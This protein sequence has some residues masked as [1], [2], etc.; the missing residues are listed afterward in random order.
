MRDAK[1]FIHL[2]IGCKVAGTYSDASG[3][4]GI[5]TGVTNGGSECEIQFFLEDGINVEEEP[6]WNDAKDVKLILRPLSSMTEE[7]GK[8]LDWSL[9]IGWVSRWDGIGRPQVLTPEE[10]RY[11]LSKGFDIFGLLH[12]GLAIEKV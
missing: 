12:S 6:T 8:E 4:I 5:L 10:F 3:S 11:L 2:Y 1:D 9:R 7:E